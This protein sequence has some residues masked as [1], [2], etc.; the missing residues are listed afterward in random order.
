MQFNILQLIIKQ[1]FF[2]HV[3]FARFTEGGFFRSRMSLCVNTD[4]TFQ[5]SCLVISGDICPNPGPSKKQKKGK[6]KEVTASKF[7]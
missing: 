7:R 1:V 3:V 2:H 5:L 4:S 6:E